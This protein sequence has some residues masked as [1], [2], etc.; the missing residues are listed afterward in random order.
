MLHDVRTRVRMVCVLALNEACV[1][2]NRRVAVAKVE[3]KL[4]PSL[5]MGRTELLIETLRLLQ[6]ALLPLNIK[7]C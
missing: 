4:L 3:F 2:K 5:D 1:K 7:P 6:V